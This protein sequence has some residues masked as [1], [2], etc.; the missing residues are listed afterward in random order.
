MQHNKGSCVLAVY[1]E[2]C[3]TPTCATSHACA[4]FLVICA[5]GHRSSANTKGILFQKYMYSSFSMKMA[6]N[7]VHIW[8]VDLF[9]V[10]DQ[11]LERVFVGMQ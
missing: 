10:E 8:S 11:V 6:L 4:A 9:L 7:Y 2:C 3:S 1:C 5:A